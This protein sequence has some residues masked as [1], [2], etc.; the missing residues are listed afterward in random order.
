[1]SNT[2][3]GLQ[4]GFGALGAATDFL[5]AS[6][7]AKMRSNAIKHNNAMRA[8]SAGEQLKALERKG[9]ATKQAAARAML[10][11][12]I[13]NM[14]DRASAE[15]SAAAAG[16]AGGSVEAVMRDIERSALYQQGNR[17]DS[18]ENAQRSIAQE[19]QNTRLQSV[20]GDD[21]SV[22]AKPSLASSVLGLGISAVGIYDQHQPEG[23]KTSN[24]L[25]S[26]F[27]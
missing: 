23:Q 1:M 7:Q 18:H 5:V 19:K 12:S 14:Q 16:V 20:M 10:A 6:E 11:D 15:V 21:I 24:V 2:M 9:T 17:L 27:E 8:I 25:D 4:L 13:V 22:V 26:L 3:M